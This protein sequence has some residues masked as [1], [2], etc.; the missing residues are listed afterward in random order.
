MKRLFIT[1]LAG[2]LAGS[3]AA[4]LTAQSAPTS[5]SPSVGTTARQPI[6][7]Q[8][9][10]LE[11][12]VTLRLKKS[13]LSEV[14]TA[15]GKQ[16]GVALT[17]AANAADEPAIVYASDQPAREVMHQIAVLFGYR[18]TR[19]GTPGQHSYEIYQ[20]LRSQQEE[21]ALRNQR[22]TLA[23]RALQAALGAR[24]ALAA[25][26]PEQLAREAAA[27]EEALVPFERLPAEQRAVTMLTPAGRAAE[28][29][30]ARAYRLREMADPFRRALLRVPAGLSS[31]AWNALAEG[32][33]LR[34]STRPGPGEQALP[35]LATAAL[36]QAQPALLPP[37]ARFGFAS[38]Q[39]E[40]SFRTAEQQGA[41]TWSQAAVL[42]ITV[43]LSLPSGAGDGQ[44]VLTVTPEA[45]S[46]DG[47]LP[48][49]AAPPSLILAGDRSAASENAAE[50]EP[51]VDPA[52]QADPILG[53][54]RPFTVSL[55]TADRGDPTVGTLNHV[56]PQ[57]AEAYGI[58]LVADAYRA[59][60][61]PLPDLTAGTE[62]A[63]GAPA[64]PENALYEV[65]NRLVSPTAHWSRQG[66]FVHV[67]R[68]TWAHDRH[69]EIPPRVA[70]AWAARL[71]QDGTLAL[72]DAAR[73]A[74]ALRDEQLASFETVMREHGLTV[75]AFSERGEEEAPRQ[76]AMLRAYGRLSSPL[77]Q[78]LRAGG[79]V[80]VTAMPPDAQRWLRRALSLRPEAGVDPGAAATVDGALTL[81]LATSHERDEGDAE[82]AIVAQ[83]GEPPATVGGPVERESP[84]EVS[85]V[86]F[87]FVAPGTAVQ[88]FEVVLPRVDMEPFATGEDTL[89][90][91]LSR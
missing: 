14:V 43:R 80:P 11:Q 86:L 8:D 61:L 64:G 68:R 32:E 12:R 81:A 17:A 2:T 55:A 59:E 34:L 18:W 78:R 51:V 60:P 40:A 19:K 66:A 46:E 24:L 90:P 33:T 45:R 74:L 76:A 36:R 89:D 79:P 48:T 21:E 41:Q 7:D 87:R 62:R 49:L 39:D 25:R 50:A 3:L 10:R 20:D 37:G 56:L 77:R 30:G 42:G 28:R 44:A 72:D 69:A 23:L 54:R 29:A 83:A 38:A 15:I 67:R 16:I 4:P 35:A 63:P 73:L 85:S 88:T 13:P 47:S 71:R 22:R 53:A 5:T 82:P 6:L 65:L 57:I 9:P 27:E 84:A 70:A 31:A 75:S 52:W 26:T 1:F 91:A 58:N